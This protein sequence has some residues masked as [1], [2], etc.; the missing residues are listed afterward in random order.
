MRVPGLGLGQV[1]VHGLYRVPQ[2]SSKLH[3][4]PLADNM[5]VHMLTWQHVAEKVMCCRQQDC[6]LHEIGHVAGNR[7]TYCRKQDDMLQMCYSLRHSH[8]RLL[9]C[10]IFAQHM[11]K[12]HCSF[13]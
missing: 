8:Y 4:C 9:I 12:L 7:A 13:L 6:I 1:R 2:L 11:S 10:N 3:G 5:T